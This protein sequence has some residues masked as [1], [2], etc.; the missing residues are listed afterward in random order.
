MKSLRTTLEAIRKGLGADTPDLNFD[1]VLHRVADAGS[2]LGRLQVTCCAPK[3]N[4][5]YT[6]ILQNLN[7]VQVALSKERGTGH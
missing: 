2:Q 4:V 7:T 6:E 5:L 3:R 1:V